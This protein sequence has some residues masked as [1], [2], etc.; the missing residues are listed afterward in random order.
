MKLMHLFKVITVIFMLLITVA[1]STLDEP[2][3]QIVD[4]IKD[5]NTVNGRF[6]EK[7][8]QLD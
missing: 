1:C 2:E 7:M 5:T 6:D 3:V 8:I 4:N